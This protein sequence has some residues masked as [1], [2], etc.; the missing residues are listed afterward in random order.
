M[1]Q[2]AKKYQDELDELKKYVKESYKFF[3][4][5]REYFNTTRKFVLQGNLSSQDKSNIQA[6]NR[7]PLEFNV[8]ESYVS[9]LLG[10][11]SKQEPSVEVFSS[12]SKNPPDPDMVDYIE[13]HMRSIFQDF[14]RYEIY[15]DGMT[16]GYSAI[17]LNYDYENDRSFNHKI[18]CCRVYDPL[19]VGWDPSAR[20]KH[21][22]D[23]DYCYEFYPK[24]KEELEEMGY[25]IK[26]E[27]STVYAM[28]D[29]RWTYKIGGKEV[30]LVCDLYKKK[31]KRIKIYRLADNTTRTEK[32]YEKL[33]EF[34]EKNKF[35]QPPAIVQQRYS[36]QTTVC[37]YRFIENQMLEYKETDFSILPIIFV[38]GNSAL[39]RE[40]GEDSNVKQVTKAYIHNAMDAQRLKNMTGQQLAHSIETMVEHKMKIALESVPTGYEEAYYNVQYPGNYVYKAYNDQGMQLPPPQEVMKMPLPPEVVNTFNGTDQLIQSIL[41]NYDAMLGINKK[42]LSGVAIVEGATQSNAAAMPFIVNLLCSLQHLANGILDLIPKLYVTP[43]SIPILTAE[44]KR[45]FVLINTNKVPK[46]GKKYKNTKPIHISYYGSDLNV[47]VKPSVNFEVQKQRA[48]ET[49]ISLS[50]ALPSFA[51]I[52]NGKGLPILCDNLEIRGADRLKVI[53]EEQVEQQQM[54]QK[55][56]MSG[57]LPQMNPAIMKVQLEK[58]KMILE[59]QIKQAELQLKQQELQ[60]ERF[61]VAADLVSSHQDNVVQLEK[62]KTER[63]VHHANTILETHD[64]LHRHRTDAINHAKDLMNMAQDDRHHQDKINNQIENQNNESENIQ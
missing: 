15:R 36:F 19:L 37:R 17:R 29:L 9:R 63:A 33:L 52:I 61:K 24:T 51:S 50:Q 8:L 41:G 18:T 39:I 57:K 1:A 56:Q 31:R 64:Q 49:L 44:N 4:H 55:L 28:D 62:A 59:N 42:D 43:R 20:E 12:P 58:Q 34:Y 30:I 6:L 13:G 38:D 48:L 10:E 21:K 16:G 2:I 5:N 25:E 54:M 32:E 14:D 40:D 27:K 11:F 45:D 47:T 46:D 22:G 26:C 35:E 7:P 3:H 60:D 53:A 23:G